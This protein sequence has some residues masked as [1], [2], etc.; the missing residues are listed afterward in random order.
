MDYIPQYIE[1]KRN[2]ASVK[3][4]HPILEKSLDVT[5]GCMV[6]QE[7]VM[8]IVRDI[9]GYSLGRS[10]LMRR[11]MSKKKH[12]VMKQ[13]KEYFIYGKEENGEVVIPGALRKWRR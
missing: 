9:A 12:D 4:E 11:A 2:P 10:D 5:Y 8:Q 13:E 6:Y 1:G 7:Q 3:Y